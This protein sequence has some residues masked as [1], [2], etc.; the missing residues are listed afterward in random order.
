MRPNEGQLASHGPE[1]LN[2]GIHIN[3]HRNMFVNCQWKKKVEKLE[4]SS[5][6]VAVI[7]SLAVVGIGIPSSTTLWLL[8]TIQWLL[9][10]HPT[11][12]YTKYPHFLPRQR[13]LVIYTP[14]ARWPSNLTAF[15]SLTSGISLHPN[16][17]NCQNVENPI[18]LHPK[19][20]GKMEALLGAAAMGQWLQRQQHREAPTTPPLPTITASEM[21][22]NS[23]LDGVDAGIR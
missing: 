19:E 9:G 2:V 23:C 12:K 18:S 22:K 6:G 15:V 11:A 1:N 5:E 3:Q 20:R 7:V 4:G 8:S 10:L 16:A 14:T 17:K 13:I 21:N